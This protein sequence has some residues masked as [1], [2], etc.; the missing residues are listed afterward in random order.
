LCFRMCD[1]VATDVAVVGDERRTSSSPCERLAGGLLPA[2]LRRRADRHRAQ[3]CA[4][5]RKPCWFAGGSSA[6]DR[7]GRWI[8]GRNLCA[9]QERG[10]RAAWSRPVLATRAWRRA[11]LP[12]IRL[13]SAE[14]A[15]QNCR[16]NNKKQTTIYT[17]R[18]RTPLLRFSESV[19]LRAAL[20]F[21]R[22]TPPK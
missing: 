1:G 7:R 21:A 20:R 6:S 4:E 5:V 9:A 3:L 2:C 14:C 8:R 15:G 18:G 13:A 19:S 17:S 12:G 22:V 10:G 11:A 16:R